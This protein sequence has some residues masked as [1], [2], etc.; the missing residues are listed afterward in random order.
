MRAKA[1]AEP[2][3]EL[4]MEVNMLAPVALKIP[5]IPYAVRRTKNGEDRRSRFT[6][7]GRSACV[8]CDAGKG[9]GTNREMS[10]LDVITVEQNDSQTQHYGK[11]KDAEKEEVA[12]FVESGL[13]GGIPH[14]PRHSTGYDEQTGRK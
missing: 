4:H 7:L 2:N 8:G 6:I 12:N 3:R 1:V 10:G 5:S 14:F 11:E 9:R 13:Q